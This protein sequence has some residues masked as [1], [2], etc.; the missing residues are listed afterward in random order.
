MGRLHDNDQEKVMRLAVETADLAPPFAAPACCPHCGDWLI[1]PTC[2]EFV[3]GG[4]IRHHWDCEGCG[5]GFCTSVEIE[6]GR[7]PIPALTE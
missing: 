1:A 7:R 3:V 2:S 6:P 4:E 5:E